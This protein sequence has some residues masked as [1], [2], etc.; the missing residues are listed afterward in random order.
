MEAPETNV[1]NKNSYYPTCHIGQ[2]ILGSCWARG[3]KIQAFEQLF[4][5]RATNLEHP[6]ITT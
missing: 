2:R 4:D 5:L 1:H 3:P 6:D